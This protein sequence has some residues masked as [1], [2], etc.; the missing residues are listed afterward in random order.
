MWFDTSYDRQCRGETHKT[1][2]NTRSKNSSSLLPQTQRFNDYTIC[3]I[4]KSTYLNRQPTNSTLNL[5]FPISFFLPCQ[6]T[7]LP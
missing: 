1:Q 4:L 3:A 6:V 2:Y 7:N 5:P